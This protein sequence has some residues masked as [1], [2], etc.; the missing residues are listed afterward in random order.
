LAQLILLIS[1]PV[2]AVAG[3]FAWRHL[4]H[5]RRER[6][7]R[8]PFPSDWID[9]LERNVP[10][11]GALPE[12]LRAQL[13]S[14]INVFLEEKVFIG[15]GGLEIGD[16]IRITIAA[17]ACLL[18]LNRVT[19]YYPGFTT[20]LVYPDT[21]V[22]R[23]IIHDGEVETVEEQA[24]AGES[25][26]RG[27]VVLS[28]EDVLRAAERGHWVENV[29]LH[30]FTHKLDEENE[31]LDGLPVLADPSQRASWAEV[32]NREFEALRRNVERGVPTLLDDDGAES[33]SEFFAVATETFFERPRELS[34]RHPLLY[35]QLR[36][37]FRLDP[38][39][40]KEAR[41]R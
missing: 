29:A 13:H 15:C 9:I 6:A 30:E 24:R 33:P 7:F 41:N 32:F 8:R 12:P 35:E 20:I 22:A 38:A 23:E 2:A 34:A 4:R 3:W 18:L 19:D 5:T 27:P 26:D 11:Y 40:W 25:W 39:S 36:R 31:R 16:E 14:H 28:W 17:Y 37:Y 1:L 10:L 21:Y